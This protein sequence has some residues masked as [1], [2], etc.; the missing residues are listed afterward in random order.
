MG[1]SLMTRNRLHVIETERSS[2]GTHLRV[3]LIGAPTGVELARLDWSCWRPACDRLGNLTRI[4]D[5]PSPE[6]EDEMK[7]TVNEPFFSFPPDIAP[8]PRRGIEDGIEIE[9]AT[10]LPD[11][12]RPSRWEYSGQWN[13]LRGS[14][15]LAPAPPQ[16]SPRFLNYLHRL[17]NEIRF[18]RIGFEGGDQ[19]AAQV[20]LP[21]DAHWRDVTAKALDFVVRLVL[22]QLAWWTGPSE[23]VDELLDTAGW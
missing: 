5:I 7:Q 16:V 21:C 23:L 14:V 6:L 17:N 15:M 20:V 9:K 4:L 11:P 22:P 10:Y 18:V 8:A 12:C 19:L 3:P 1:S 2:S 13:R